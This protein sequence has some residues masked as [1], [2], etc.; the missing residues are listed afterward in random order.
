MN[1]PN[2]RN[3]RIKVTLDD[4]RALV[5]GN[6]RVERDDAQADADDMIDGHCDGARVVGVD[7]VAVDWRGDEV[8]HV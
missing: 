4:G 6:V 8:A 2:T 1:T 5:I 3:F 7:V